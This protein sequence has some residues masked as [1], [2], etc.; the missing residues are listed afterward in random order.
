MQELK[1]FV[2]KHFFKIMIANVVMKLNS[3]VLF[4][5]LHAKGISSSENNHK[6]R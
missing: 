1:N 3:E 5:N 4:F 2:L 6:N